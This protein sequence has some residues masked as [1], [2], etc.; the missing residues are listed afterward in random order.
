MAPSKPEATV[1]D[2][3]TRIG[4]Q[5]EHQAIFDDSVLDFRLGSAYVEVN[6]YWHLHNPR[7]IQK[8]QRIAEQLGK[9]LLVIDAKDVVEKPVKAYLSLIQFITTACNV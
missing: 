9:N 8:D 7:K 3:L 5:F 2:W 4:V 6:G 1:L